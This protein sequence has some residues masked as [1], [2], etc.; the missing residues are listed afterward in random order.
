MLAHRSKQY[1]GY[2]SDVLI[3]KLVMITLSVHYEQQLALKMR[4]RCG[5][6]IVLLWTSLYCG[7][8]DTVSLLRRRNNS[9]AMEAKLT[10]SVIWKFYASEKCAAND[11]R[12]TVS[13][14]NDVTIA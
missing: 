12:L 3:S 6:S 10:S 13:L 14:G 11:G 8:R 4:A 1:I 7:F 9:P 2:K 5:I